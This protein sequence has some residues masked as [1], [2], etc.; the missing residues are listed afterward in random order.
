VLHERAR[1][2]ILASLA[3]RPGGLT[4]AELKTLVSLTDGNLSRQIQVL[5]E[6]G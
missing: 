6:E 2:G 1:L 3:G 4:F 5:Q